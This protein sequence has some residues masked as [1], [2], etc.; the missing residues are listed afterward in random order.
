MVGVPDV[1]KLRYAALTP[2][3]CAVNKRQKDKGYEPAHIG[4]T[5]RV[6]RRALA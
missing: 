2:D 5:L 4:F 1:Y 6:Q 3:R